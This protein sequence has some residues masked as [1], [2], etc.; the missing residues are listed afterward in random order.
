MTKNDPYTIEQAQFLSHVQEKLA[1][2]YNEFPVPAHGYEHVS[3]VARYA[4]EIAI[5]EN[6]KSVF[7][8]ELAGWLHDIGHVPEHHHGATK[9]HH[10]LSYE[11]LQEWFRD[12]I[13][14]QA[15]LT[16]SEKLELL[17]AVRYH[18]NNAADKYDTAWILRDADKLETL[19]QIGV[20]RHIEYHGTDPAV[21]SQTMRELF[22][23]YY[24]IQTETAKQIAAE[25][26]M[27]EPIEKKYLEI[28]RAGIEEVSL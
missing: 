18:W 16:E 26:S 2:L 4:K 13:R 27:M 6:A 5:K 9:R 15:A 1:A 12:D 3:R 23:I 19:G 8:C 7:L 17:Y 11:M 14:F 28:L 21:L 24:W 10:E 22:D 25:Q 20:Q